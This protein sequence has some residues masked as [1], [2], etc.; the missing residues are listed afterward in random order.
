MAALVNGGGYAE[1]CLAEQES[2]FKIPGDLSFNEAACI[3]ECYFTAWSNLVQRG[4]L[5]RNQKVLIHG[6]TS[7]IGIAAIQIAKIFNSYVI[8]TVGNVEKTEFCKNL[9]VN[10]VINYKKQDFFEVI[11]KSDVKSVNLILDYVGGDYISKNINL[12][13]TEGTLVNIGFLKGSTT[14]INFMKIMLKRL[15]ILV[16]HLESE[17]ISLKV[18]F[19]QSLKNLFSLLIERKIKCFVDSVFK[20]EDVVKAHQK[21][22]EGKHIGKIIL[23]HRNLL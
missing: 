8:T 10:Q 18:R 20:F 13:D 11:K 22:D 16:L 23:N 6:G 21:I 7:G 9:G 12:L 2:T 17:I 4:R 15:Q 19:Y 14:E 5:T 3:P 1:F